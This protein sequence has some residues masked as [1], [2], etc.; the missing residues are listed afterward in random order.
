MG[1]GCSNRLAISKDVFKL[2]LNEVTF[3]AFNRSNVKDF[4]G[5]LTCEIM[6]E[7]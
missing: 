3:D 7:S 6:S 2:S 4:I 5:W 1:L